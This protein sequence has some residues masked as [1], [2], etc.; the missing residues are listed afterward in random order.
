MKKT[1]FSL[2][3]P[4]NSA[5]SFNIEACFSFGKARMLNES[6]KKEFHTTALGNN[7]LQIV[8]VKGLDWPL[9]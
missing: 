9:H 7:N 2:N 3:E 8:K 6:S 5:V 1:L 4:L